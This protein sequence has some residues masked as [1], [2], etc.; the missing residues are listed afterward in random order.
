MKLSHD[1]N[2]MIN[3]TANTSRPEPVRPTD[4]EMRLQAL[5]RSKDKLL[6]IVGHDLRTS[7]GGV[8]SLSDMLEKKLAVGEL[9]EARRLNGLIRRATLDADDLLKDLVAWTRKSRQDTH[10]HLMSV[11]LSELVESEVAR[12]GGA[13]QQKRQRIEIEA[14]EIG[15]IRADPNMLRSILRNLLTNALKFSNPGDPITVRVQRRTGYWEFQVCDQGIGMSAEVQE[16]LL[17]LDERKQRPGTA[18]E[19]G[20]GFGL[21]LCEDFI[22]RHGGE[23]SWE[24]T[25]GAGSTFSFSIPELLG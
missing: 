11:D 12:L 4:E 2:Q 1:S 21:L 10:F 13:A 8:L 3:E 16:L 5:N 23:L 20:S 18:G 24:S 19:T 25:P 22:Q 9:Q 6:S 15:I 14:H 7:I 17:K